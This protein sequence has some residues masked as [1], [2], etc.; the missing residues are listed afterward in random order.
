MDV[1]VHAWLSMQQVP[2]KPQP[3]SSC[4]HSRPWLPLHTL[5]P[6][7]AHPAHIQAVHVQPLCLSRQADGFWFNEA[8]LSPLLL[9]R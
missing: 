8:D 3:I 5:Y 7:W 2:T 9:K 4:S 1:L 6:A